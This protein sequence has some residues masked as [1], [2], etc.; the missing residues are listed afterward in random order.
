MRSRLSHLPPTFEHLSTRWQALQLRVLRHI[1][2]RL[3]PLANLHS[4]LRPSTR[5]SQS[6]PSYHDPQRPLHLFA[7]GTL[8]SPIARRH[9]ARSMLR[10]YVF[11]AYTATTAALALFLLAWHTSTLPL[12]VSY[13]G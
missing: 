7:L 12:G 9:R 5:R 6:H 2:A 1:A 10:R 3:S 8:V 4:L 13:M 11:P